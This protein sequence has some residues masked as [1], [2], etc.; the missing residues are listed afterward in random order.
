MAF[1][2]L[3]SKPRENLEKH[4]HMVWSCRGPIFPRLPLRVL[5]FRHSCPIERVASYPINCWT[6]KWYSLVKIKILIGSIYHELCFG[7]V[8]YRPH[9]RHRIWWMYLFRMLSFFDL[10]VFFFCLQGVYVCM[11][12]IVVTTVSPSE[13]SW[14]GACFVAWMSLDLSFS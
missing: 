7:R 13:P 6:R 12:E 1:I 5:R 10:V 14:S 9:D 2:P 11:S 8:F 4:L 3:S